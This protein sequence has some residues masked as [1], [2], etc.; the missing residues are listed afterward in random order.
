[1]VLLPPVITS[2]LQTSYPPVMR[3]HNLSIECGRP[4]QMGRC[5]QNNVISEQSVC[6]SG[7]Y[8]VLTSPAPCTQM[9]L[10]FIL[11]E[12]LV[13]MFTLPHTDSVWP[14]Y[15]LSYHCAREEHPHSC[16]EL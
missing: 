12:S 14:K 9:F 15:L 8:Q 6:G 2:T 4:C 5:V 7:S 11:Q 10:M 1:M 16:P 13:T 3:K